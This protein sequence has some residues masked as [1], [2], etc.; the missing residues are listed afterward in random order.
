M[1]KKLLIGLFL[2]AI[3]ASADVA[4]ACDECKLQTRGR[5]A[6]L[7]TCIFSTTWCWCSYD[8]PASGACI[9]GD[10]C[11]EWCNFNPN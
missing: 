3:V 4:E 8:W 10:S 1:Q 11:A 9:D 5:W 2:L 7:Y 6:G